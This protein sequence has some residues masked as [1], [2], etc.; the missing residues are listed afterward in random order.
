MHS[1]IFKLVARKP[2]HLFSDLDLIAN[3]FVVQRGGLSTCWFLNSSMVLEV[4]TSSRP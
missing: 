4:I 3:D 2:Q 1:L